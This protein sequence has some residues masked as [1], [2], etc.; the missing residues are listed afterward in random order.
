M[1]N[2]HVSLEHILHR[3]FVQPGLG[4][5]IIRSRTLILHQQS[6]LSRF[7]TKMLMVESRDSAHE[8]GFNAGRKY[9]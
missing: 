1:D 6:S 8:R 4:L 7:Q 3:S 2:K 9:A 5:L